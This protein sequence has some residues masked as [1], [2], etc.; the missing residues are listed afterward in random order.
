MSRVFKIVAS[1]LNG[2]LSPLKTPNSTLFQTLHKT[3]FQISKNSLFQTLKNFI[4]D[5]QEN[6]TS[7]QIIPIS[8]HQKFHYLVPKNL[9]TAPINPISNPQNTLFRPQ[10]SNPKNPNSRCKR[11]LN[12]V[13]LHQ[14]L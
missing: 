6:S 5:P 12:I 13:T 8:D 10:V 3:L 2:L 9:I 11:I 14:N 4:L 7:A 1:T